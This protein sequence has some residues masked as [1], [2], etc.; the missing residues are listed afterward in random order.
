LSIEARAALDDAAAR[1]LAEQ[2]LQRFPHGR[3]RAL[4]ERAK[5][6]FDHR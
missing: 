6:R 5:R 2:Y 1:G 4:A 3:F